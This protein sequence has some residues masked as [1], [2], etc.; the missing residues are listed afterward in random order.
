MIDILSVRRSQIEHRSFVFALYC[1]EFDEE[2]A[3]DEYS[4]TLTRL[5][6]YL[7]VKICVYLWHLLDGGAYEK[8]PDVERSDLR[9]ARQRDF[10][11]W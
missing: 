5:I 1:A 8:N 6:D 10:R 4:W 7:A 9:V 2:K 3:T 11:L